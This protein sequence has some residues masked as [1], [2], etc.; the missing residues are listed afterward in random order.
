VGDSL[1]LGQILLNLV[2]NAIKFTERGKVVVAVEPEIRVGDHVRLRFSIRDTGIGLLSEQQ[3][4]LFEVFSQGDGSTTRRY[5]GTGLGLAIS[6]KLVDLMGGKISVESTPGVGSTF[7][8]TVPFTV[9]KAE[10]EHDVTPSPGAASETKPPT[11]DGARVLLVEDNAINQQV[12]QEILQGFGLNVEIADNGRQ[13]V[14]LLRTATSRYAVVLMDLQMPEMDGFEATCVIRENLGLT[15]LPIIAMTAHA[16][17]EERRHCLAHG[18]N[19]HV[20]KPI[21][22][23][24]L[25]AALTRWIAPHGN[26]SGAQ[27]MVPAP[28]FPAYLPGVDLTSALARLS[29]NRE[30]LLK[31]LRNFGTQWSGAPETIQTALTAGDIQK[32]RLAVHTLR[33]VAANLSIITVAVASTALEQALKGE[34]RGETERCLEAL[35]ATLT[36]VLAGLGVLP[37]SPPPPSPTGLPDRSLLERQISDLATLLL[38][39]NLKAK[40]CFATFR[41]HLGTGEW[42][43]V[44]N[45]LERQLDRL[46][47]AAAGKTLAEVAELLGFQAVNRT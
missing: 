32:A 34:E 46:D 42:S 36:P 39:H 13:A 18:M 9:D 37:P 21:D 6:R 47:F 35:G 31:L 38:Q 10:E 17:E 27:E 29:G 41:A 4:R 19:D 23:S 44:L 16:L 26:E 20:A 3:V 12:A 24:A 1:R 40:S 8:V 43:E 2:N 11:L 14:D 45:R 22:P 30:L 28:D 7:T 33:G 5:G 25:L 15:D